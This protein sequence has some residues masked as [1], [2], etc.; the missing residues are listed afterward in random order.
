MLSQLR[1]LVKPI[2]KLLPA[3]DYKVLNSQLFFLIWVSFILNKV[4][5]SM[6]ELFHSR[7]NVH[8]NTSSKASSSRTKHHFGLVLKTLIDKLKRQNN[9]HPF[10]FSIDATVIGLTSKLLWHYGEVKLITGLNI[11]SRGIGECLIPFGYNHQ[12]KYQYD[13]RRGHSAYGQGLCRL[14][15]DRKTLFIIRIKKNMMKVLN[16]LGLRTV[17]F[18]DEQGREY[19]L[20]TNVTGMSDGKVAASY[21]RRW[22]IEILW[23]FLKQELK[24]DK[25]ITK[26]VNSITMQIY[27]VLIVYLLLQLMEGDRK[28]GNKLIDKLEISKFCT[29][30][31]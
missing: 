25:L 13:T 7:I 26:N 27:V 14:E 5:E 10:L 2:L 12:L 6:R 8:Y 19:R 31:R 18:F 11:L 1:H 23:R 22:E 15:T 17:T 28:W 3:H 29:F 20:A 30:A 21:R 4:I 9:V 24:L 16:I